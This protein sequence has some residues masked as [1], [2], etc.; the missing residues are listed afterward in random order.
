MIELNEELM[1]EAKKSLK[2]KGIKFEDVKNLP[3]IRRIM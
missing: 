3:P 1:R 2:E